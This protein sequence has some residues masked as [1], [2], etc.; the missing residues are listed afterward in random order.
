M[1][2]FLNNKNGFINEYLFSYW[3]LAHSVFKN[4]FSARLLARFS[5]DNW[6][7]KLLIALC[8][9]LWRIFGNGKIAYAWNLIK[10]LDCKY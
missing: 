9:P 4:N 3:T 1:Q 8:V 10:T 7:V 6:G 2:G 5:S